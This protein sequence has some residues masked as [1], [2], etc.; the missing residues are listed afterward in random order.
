MG[1]I[2]KSWASPRGPSMNPVDKRLAV[3]VDDHPVEYF[4]FEGI[5]SRGSSPRGTTAPVPS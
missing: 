5:I 1:G 4:D 2:L 3:M